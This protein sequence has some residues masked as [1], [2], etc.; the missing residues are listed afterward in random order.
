MIRRASIRV[1]CLRCQHEGTISASA[2]E[3]LGLSANAP[4]STFVK[5]LRCS[6]CGS[7]SVSA[8]RVRSEIDVTHNRRRA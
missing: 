7:G 2:L 6:K 3:R 1:T 4:I 8:R 5:R